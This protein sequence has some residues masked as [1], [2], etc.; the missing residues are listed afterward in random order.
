MGKDTSVTIGQAETDAHKKSERMGK[1]SIW[2][3]LFRFSGPAI[4][5]QVVGASYNMVDTVFIGRLGTAPLAAMTV[6]NPLMTIF[7]S[8][9][10][11]IG[12]GGSSLIARR[13]G[14]GD[15]EGANR[16]AGGCIT[17]FAVVSAIVTMLCLLNLKFLLRLFGADDTVLPPAISYMT[18]EAA[19]M[20]LDFLLLVLV[21]L[22]RVEGNPTLA[23]AGMI[24][25]GVMNCIWDPLLGYGIGPFPKLGMAGFAYATSVGR[26]IAVSI[27]VFYLLS[28]RSAYR[29]KLNYFRPNLK[30][31]SDIYR[32]GASMTVRMAASSISQI[33]AARTAASFGDIPLAV[34]GVCMKASTFG[35][36]P[37]MGIGQGMLPLVGYNFGANKKE[38]VREVVWKATLASLISGFIFWIIAIL[39]PAQ[40]MSLFSTD[41]NFLAAA[42]PAFRIYTV[43][44]FTAGVQTVLSFFFQ[45]IGK[46]FASLV[47]TSSRHLIFL[48][49]S[50]LILPRLFG[51]TGLWA[52]YPAADG[53]SIILTLIWAVIEFRRQEIPIRLGSLHR[54][55]KTD[56]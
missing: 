6:A 56:Q 45:G 4:I 7:R 43:V 35:H 10:Y 23:S 46:G 41:P 27:L 16:A 19:F 42:G 26:G 53:L 28:G 3:L 30:L 22:I 8:I 48:I 32:V 50:L 11:G 20:P 34:V 47:V 54:K 1:D 9:A 17:L 14:A 31:A 15:K 24:T 5:A 38:R 55:T 51:L 18:V 25:A 29:F 13:L 37:N 52:A 12:I 49:P 40:V 21:E 44:I 33:I 36:T 2:R 39:F